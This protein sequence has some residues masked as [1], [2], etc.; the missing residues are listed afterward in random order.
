RIGARWMSQAPAPRAQAF[1]GG[2][3]R[4]SRSCPPGAIGV[5]DRTCDLRRVGGL[6]RRW[7]SWRSTDL[8]EMP[9]AQDLHQFRLRDLYRRT[10]DISRCLPQHR[11]AARCFARRARC[12]EPSCYGMGLFE[13]STHLSDEIYTARG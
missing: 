3:H 6:D 2:R 4:A 12:A 5:E 7:P 10:K 9:R 11:R 8:D 1:V 13:M